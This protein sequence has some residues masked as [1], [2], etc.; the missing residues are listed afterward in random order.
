MPNKLITALKENKNKIRTRLAVAT[1]T[2]VAIVIAAAVLNK[3]N[4]QQSDIFLL[5][6]P[7]G[8]TADEALVPIES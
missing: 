3:L 7:A 1:G 2:V 8:E 4:Q 6:I 5:E